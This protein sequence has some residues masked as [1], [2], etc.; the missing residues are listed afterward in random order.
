MSVEGVYRW[1][2][3]LPSKTHTTTS[4]VG[5]PN[6]Y[7][8]LFED[9]HLKVR[10]IDVQKHITPAW[11]YDTQQS[12]LDVF[13]EAKSAREFLAR[14]PRALAVAKGAAERLRRRE[15]DPDELGLMVQSTREV[16]EYRATTMTKSALRRLKAAG[17]RR[18]PGEYVKYVVART[19]GP[20]DARS[21]PVELFASQ[22]PLKIQ[23]PPTY[24]VEFYLRLLA[25][26]VETL[27]APFGLEEEALLQ[28][29][30]GRASSPRAAK[31]GPLNAS[32]RPAFVRAGRLAALDVLPR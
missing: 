28:W 27:L 10:G 2:V 24:K 20:P 17:T 21:T 26:S 32:G 25:R 5:V 22:G 4:M 11:I 6:R 8:G 18:N 15:V 31:L 16:E 3:F 9:G 30:L 14:I 19:A 7:Y 12:M 23:G 29:F 13:S 1:I